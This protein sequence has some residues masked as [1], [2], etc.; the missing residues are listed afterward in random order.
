MRARSWALCLL[1]LLGL[2]LS[3]QAQSLHREWDRLLKRYVHPHGR[4]D[5]ASFRADTAAVRRYVERLARTSLSRASRQERMAYWIN[6]WNA[7]TVYALLKRLPRRSVLEGHGLLGLHIPGWRSFWR[8]IR[9]SRLGRTFPLWAIYD[10]LRALSQED[11][12][13][14]FALY[15]PARG[16]P[17]LRAEAYR[18][19]RIAEQLD[20]QT[21]IFLARYNR[22]PDAETT[23]RLSRLF[24]WHAGLFARQAGS[25]QRWL[26]PYFEGLVASRLAYNG[27]RIVYAPYDW[28]L[29]DRPEQEAVHE[30]DRGRSRTRF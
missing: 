1:L 30:A 4:I 21:R 20:D 2:G 16:G 25:V 14:L 17:P 26:A 8:S 28:T 24:E 11:P 15:R 12:R 29:D 10:S 13:W 22:I 23:I 3:G 9:L 18:A 5:Y 7:T 27:Y 6:L 19:E